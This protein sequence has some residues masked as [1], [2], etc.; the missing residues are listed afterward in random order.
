MSEYI[1]KREYF[2]SSIDKLPPLK[3]GFQRVV[4]ITNKNSAEEIK[5]NG[6]NYSGTLSST[7]RS[8]SR[9][10]DCEYSSTDPRFSFDGAVVVVMDVPQEEM[11][12][13]ENVAKSPENV[14]AKYLVGIFDVKK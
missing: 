2:A 8:W 9:A 4:H 10:E 3:D 6:L 7:A 5:S 11:L 13:H 14:P 12:L 1:S